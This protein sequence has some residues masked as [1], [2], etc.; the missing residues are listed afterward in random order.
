MDFLILSDFAE[1]IGAKLYLQ[2][3]GWDVLTV[4]DPFPHSRNIGVAVGIAAPWSDTNRRF[5]LSLRVLSEERQID[6]MAAQGQMETG[7][8]AG[9][10]AGAKQLIMVALNGPV[11]FEESGEYVVMVSIDGEE[12]RR[13]PFRVVTPPG[14]GP[15]VRASA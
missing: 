10:P 3:G 1:V 5:E 13:R 4:V 14:A 2:G 11:T 12:V 15:V 6:L 9:I 8:P 7:R